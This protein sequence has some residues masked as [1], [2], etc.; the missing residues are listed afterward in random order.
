MI[1]INKDECKLKGFLKKLVIGNYAKLD[2]RE[3]LHSKIYKVIAKNEL[4][5]LYIVKRPEDIEE[6]T[7]PFHSNHAHTI[8]N[9]FHK[10][11][12]TSVTIMDK[13]E[14]AMGYLMELI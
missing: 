12:I 6:Y 10:G 14:F 13:D 11:H 9:Q 4:Q 3:F 2:Y 5:L 7:G 1:V 8:W